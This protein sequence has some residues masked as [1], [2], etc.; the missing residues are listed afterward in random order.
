MT[1]ARDVFW[2]ALRWSGLEHLR[3]EPRAGAVVAVA[4]LTGRQEHADYRLRYRISCDGAWRA[5]TVGV[6]VTAGGRDR[7]LVLASDGAGTWTD[8]AGRRL[9]QV[10]G[11]IDVDIAATPFTNTL[12]IRRLGLPAGGT[13]DVRAAWIRV[14]SLDVEPLDQRY[15]RLPDGE[16]G[17][18]WRYE[19]PAHA[20]TTDLSV[21]ADGVV[22]DY[23]PFF[24]R[25]W[26]PP[27][28]RADL[29]RVVVFLV[30]D[31]GRLLLMR[32]SLTKDHAP[33][34]WEPGSGRLEPGESPAT[35]V[36]REAKEETGL[37][38][39]ILS[40]IDTF[41][42]ERGVAR[43]PTLA[44]TFHCRVR[45]G[46]LTLSAEHDAARWVARERVLDEAVAES[47]RG[48][49]ERLLAVHPASREA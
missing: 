43:V 20:F 45:G 11:T 15:T 38:V 29:L 8:G 24:E 32:R 19:S 27:E 12:P 41:R 13:A 14:P 2:A 10:D 16:A 23:P 25:A 6:E 17:A 37:D 26:P 47:F 9:R 3:L 36:R 4:M 1:A 48:S 22:V 49:I 21:D 33:G 5:R 34:E 28:A 31:R 7:A 39:E 42:Y 18:R 40:P 30:E 35:A 46:R 44:M